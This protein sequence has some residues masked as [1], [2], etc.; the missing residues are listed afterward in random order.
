MAGR[1]ETWKCSIVEGSKTCAWAAWVSN[2][3]LQ[4]VCELLLLSRYRAML[5]Q[6]WQFDHIWIERGVTESAAW[7]INTRHGLCRHGIFRKEREHGFENAT[8]LWKRHLWSKNKA[9]WYRAQ[10][11]KEGLLIYQKNNSTSLRRSKY[12][13]FVKHFYL[14]NFETF[15]SSPRTIRFLWHISIDLY[16]SFG[17]YNKNGIDQPGASK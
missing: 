16:S 6:D 15:K 14:R 8:E 10:A 2:S 11:S 12:I 9:W 3:F 5:N 1:T 13:S 7:H 4:Y 17:T